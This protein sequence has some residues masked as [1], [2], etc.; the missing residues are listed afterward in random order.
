MAPGNDRGGLLV[1]GNQGGTNIG[2]SLYNSSEQL[3][4]RSEFRN[5][6]EAYQ[7]PRWLT[8]FS[9][10]MLGH[11]P[12]RLGRFSHEVLTTCVRFQPRWIITTGLAPIAHGTLEEIGNLGIRRLNYLTDDPWNPAHHAPWFLRSLPRYD[13]VFSPRRAN[14]DDIREAGCPRVEFLPFGFDPRYFHREQLPT[15]APN[16]ESAD[17]IFAG[18]AD[19]DRIPYIAAL[20]RTGLRVDAF[21]DYWERYPDTKACARGHASPDVLRWATAHAHVAL[22]LVRRANRDGHVMRSFE[23]P[24]IR[25][26]MLTE[27]T[28]EHREIFGPDGENVV[29]FC[30]VDQMVDRLR[31]LL[32]HDAE[33]VR[34]ADAA[35]GLIVNGKHTYRDRLETMLAHA[36]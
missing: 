1:V 26:C 18:G 25:A 24:A 33:R 14:L 20:V 4:L 23:V 35:H 2:W 36:G 21:G 13:V 29:Y 22:C 12:A 19:S 17:V 11:R 32:A 27:D 31:W 6:L 9:W 7:A 15:N 30:T 34:L 8:K 10:M 16:A 5:A 3:G 28:A